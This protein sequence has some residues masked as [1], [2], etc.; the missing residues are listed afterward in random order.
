LSELEVL[1][2]LQELD[3]RLSQL[4]HRYATLPE[5]QQI[6][7]VQGEEVRLGEQLDTVMIELKVLRRSQTDREAEV[8]GLEDKIAKSTSALYGGEIT[9]PK[10]AAAMQSEIESISRRQTVLEDQIIELMEQIEPFALE[11]AGIEAQ[12]NVGGETLR[13]LEEQLAAAQAEIEVE[14]RAVNTERAQIEERAGDDLVALYERNRNRMGDHTAVGRLIGTSCGACF[15]GISA[16]EIDR[17]R[18]LPSNEPSECPEC[19]ALLIR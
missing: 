19:G 11:E 12:R 10:E 15:L 14:Q 13:D 3:T 4:S 17:I 5:H 7:E 18:R 9:S 6:T 8:Q 16:V 1:V 2:Q